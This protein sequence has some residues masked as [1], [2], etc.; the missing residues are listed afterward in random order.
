M[1]GCKLLITGLSNSGKTSLLKTLKDAL[2]ISRDGKPFSLEM[3]HFNVPD[4]DSV[5]VLMDTV[6]QKINAYKTKFKKMPKTIAF[7]SVSRIFNDIEVNCNRKYNGFDIWKHVN[8]EINKFVSNINGM[9]E[10]GFNVVLIAHVMWDEKAG[11]FIETCKGNFKSIGGF[12]SVVDYAINIDVRG[13]NY[14]VQLYGNNLSRTL[15]EGLPQRQLASEFSLQKYLE[16][17]QKRATDVN[18]NWSL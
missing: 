14:E 15:I 2:V 1:A 17:I 3:P 9:V 5:D 12:L 6:E 13:N 16:K 4:Y 8:S 18:D 11:K 10:Y 7:D